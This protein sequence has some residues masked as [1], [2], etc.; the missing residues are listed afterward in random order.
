MNFRPAMDYWKSFKDL[1]KREKKFTQK[2][3][4]VIVAK[5]IEE[6]KRNKRKQNAN[7][8]FR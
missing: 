1:F 3:V 8:D 4:D 2:E 6:I 5:K 7:E